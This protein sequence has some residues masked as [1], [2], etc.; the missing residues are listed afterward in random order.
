[1]GVAKRYY[2][3]WMYNRAVLMNRL[4]KNVYDNGGMLVCRKGW[5][6][7]DTRYEVHNRQVIDS[8]LECQT[9]IDEVK[10]MPENQMRKKYIETKEQELD[11]LRSMK[12]HPFTTQLTSYVSFVL[13]GVYYYLEMNDNPFFEFYVMKYP[14]TNGLKAFEAYCLDEFSKEN[15]MFDCLFTWEINEDEYKEIA[16]LIMN[17]LI[18]EPYS[19]PVINKKRV[20]NLY[21]GRYQYE[22]VKERKEVQYEVVDY[23]EMRWINEGC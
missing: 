23:E 15:W 8:I 18:A 2:T 19:M 22:Y 3:N 6:S 4:M 12:K 20:S 1:M 14:V 5:H 17:Q 11:K 10:S 7:F 16:N 9:R 21:D 13:D